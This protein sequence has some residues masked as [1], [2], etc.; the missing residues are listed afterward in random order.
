MCACTFFTAS[1]YDR[2]PTQLE[3]MLPSPGT[4]LSICTV[5]FAKQSIFAKISCTSQ[6]LDKQISSTSYG[7][8]RQ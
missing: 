1:I 8:E 7:K 3:F 4:S 6:A 5:T 2:K